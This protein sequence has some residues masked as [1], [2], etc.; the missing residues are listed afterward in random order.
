MS[1]SSV[2]NLSFGLRCVLVVVFCCWFCLGS[3][4]LGSSFSELLFRS[5]SLLFTAAGMVG[6]GLRL[7][8]RFRLAESVQSILAELQFLGQ[9]IATPAYA[10]ARLLLGVDQLGLAQQRCDLRL[11]LGLGP[12]LRRSPSG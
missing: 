2:F 6:G 11:Q 3:G 4:S 8:L 10:M 9:P 12:L 7:Q 1:L 5:A